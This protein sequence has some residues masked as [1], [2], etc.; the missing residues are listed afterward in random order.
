MN[1]MDATK[2]ILWTE[3]DTAIKTS[4]SNFKNVKPNLNTSLCL[5]ADASIAISIALQSTR[6]PTQPSVVGA[7]KGFPWTQVK[8]ALGMP[9]LEK[10]LK[11]SAWKHSLA[12]H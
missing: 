10:M 8:N 6:T 7:K 5:K 2:I 12:T 1:A 9:A 11:E 3:T 4:R